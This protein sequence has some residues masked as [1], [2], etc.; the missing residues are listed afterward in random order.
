MLADAPVVRNRLSQYIDAGPGRIAVVH[1]MDQHNRSQWVRVTFL[2]V[3]RSGPQVCG[4]SGLINTSINRGVNASGRSP[5]P[6][7]RF[8]LIESETLKLK[9]GPRQKETIKTVEESRGRGRRSEVFNAIPCGAV[10]LATL[11][12]S[13]SRPIVTRTRSQR[14]MAHRVLLDGALHARC[15]LCRNGDSIVFLKRA[16]FS[17]MAAGHLTR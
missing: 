4:N 8:G 7:Q 11:R 6:F 2:G 13:P 17:R 9:D 15:L 16:A 14:V 10:L 12:A 3:I 5:E 1:R